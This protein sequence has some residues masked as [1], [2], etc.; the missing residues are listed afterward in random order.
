MCNYLLLSYA[1]SQIE[2]LYAPWGKCDPARK[3]KYNE[4]YTVD[5]C[6]IECKLKRVVEVCQC[7]PYYFPGDFSICTFEQLQ[8]CAFI[9]IGKI[10]KICFGGHS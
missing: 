1:R 5:A 10:R 4:N 9:E 2:N 3:L 7:K 8:D 6:G